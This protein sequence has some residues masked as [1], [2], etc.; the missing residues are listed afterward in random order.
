MFILHN[1]VDSQNI[2]SLI[3]FEIELFFNDDDIINS[4][5]LN[6]DEYQRKAIKYITRIYNDSILFIIYTFNNIINIFCI[7]ILK[8]IN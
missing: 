3:E 6:N 2:N 1:N 7:N 5:D 8:L 4:S